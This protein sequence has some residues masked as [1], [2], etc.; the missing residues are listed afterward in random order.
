[1][2][3]ATL[4]TT[5]CEPAR[6]LAR[7]GALLDL[8]PLD[9]AFL[10]L[11]VVK[12]PCVVLGSRQRASR[13]VSLDACSAASVP[14]LRRR[15]TGT[16][17]FLGQR[18]VMTSLYLP[19]VTSLMPDATCSNLLNRYT[20]LWIRALGALGLQ[21][22]YFGRETLNAEHQPVMV[23]GYDITR[24][25]RVL[26]E[27]FAGCDVGLEL[28]RS[29]VTDIEL[30]VNHYRARTPRAIAT[31][32]ERMLREFA[33]RFAA[34][35]GTEIVWDTT[36]GDAPPFSPVSYD[37]PPRDDDEPVVESRQV[38]VG[39]V[40]AVWESGVCW[41][42]GDMLASSAWLD[43]APVAYARGEPV[44]CESA[45]MGAR[46][47]DFTTLMAKFFAKPARKL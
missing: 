43:D 24:D 8:S 29:L 17:L 23:F 30:L 12:G 42:G 4:S 11:E 6:A 47:E 45:L 25:G 34:R 32:D 44:V 38:P 36:V 41:L 2:L 14:V 26:I 7:S 27:A 39:Y 33:T 13:V 21:T 18:S 5:P 19:S 16:A 28:P 20:R 1:M 3:R 31:P 40:E 46:E 10:L 15:S 22:A 35:A 37:T 9:P